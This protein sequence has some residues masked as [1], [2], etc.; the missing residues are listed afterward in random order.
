MLKGQVGLGATCL[1]L[2]FIGH[3]IFSHVGG[4]FAGHWWLLQV[5]GCFVLYSFGIIV[6]Q[7]GHGHVTLMMPFFISLILPGV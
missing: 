5:N 1:S 2:S 7:S 3:F 6:L 4:R